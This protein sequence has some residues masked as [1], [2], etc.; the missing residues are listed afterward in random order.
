MPQGMFLKFFF[1]VSSATLKFLYRK[2][3][4]H[5]SHPTGQEAPQLG[6]SV[7]DFLTPDT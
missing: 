3:G 6:V 2:L 4:G 1:I 5:P 7:Q